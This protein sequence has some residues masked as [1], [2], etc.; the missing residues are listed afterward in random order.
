MRKMT[1]K[2]KAS[3]VI[4]NLIQDIIPHL[5]LYSTLRKCYI[6]KDLESSSGWHKAFTLIEVIVS[7]TIFSII[8][9]SI[10]AIYILSS[11]TSAKSDINRAMHENLKSIITEIWEDIIKNW[12]SGVS[13]SILDDCNFNLTNNYKN[14]TELCLKSWNNYYLAK[15]STSWAWDTYTRVENSLCS[16]FQDQCYLVKNWAPLT[17]SLVSIKDLEFLVSSQNVN[18]VTIKIVL[19]PTS[20]AGVKPNLIA[21]SKL[22]FQTT[23][24]ERPF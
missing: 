3:C 24:S 21:D 11:D 22:M 7:I 6:I 17:N 1:K 19:Q 16:D 9:I 20:K 18:K 5:W 12:I 10:I 14:G 15:K 2:I 4:L 8:M 13:L 23:I